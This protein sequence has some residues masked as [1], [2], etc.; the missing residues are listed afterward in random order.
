MRAHRWPPSPA[1]GA[2]LHSLEVTLAELN[3]VCKGR[4]VPG[5]EGAL[6]SI[7]TTIFSSVPSVAETVGWWVVDL[8]EAG[9]VPELPAWLSTCIW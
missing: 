8:Q 5:T 3:N 6:N 4:T 7:V 2:S 1:S 9:T